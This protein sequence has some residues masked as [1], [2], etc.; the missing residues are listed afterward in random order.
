[1]VLFGIVSGRTSWGGDVLQ[2][3]AVYELELIKEGEKLRGDAFVK[4][5][6]YCWDQ[7][8]PEHEKKKCGYNCIE[9]RR[10]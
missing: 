9:K 8:V 5:V 4:T 2:W 7:Y 3:I 1:M 10:I 6:N